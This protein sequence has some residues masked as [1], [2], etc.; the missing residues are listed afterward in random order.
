MLAGSTPS[1]QEV[2]CSLDAFP[3]VP[4]GEAA[5]AGIL[6]QEGKEPQ[7]SLRDILVG[8]DL[9]PDGRLLNEM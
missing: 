6:L 9:F 4:D 3:P 5:S 7:E 8:L 2:P 1:L